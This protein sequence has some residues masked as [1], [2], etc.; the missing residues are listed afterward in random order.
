[1]LFFNTDLNIMDYSL[2]VGVHSGYVGPYDDEMRC[3]LVDRTWERRDDRDPDSIRGSFWSTGRL[4]VTFLAFLSPFE[5]C[6]CKR[7]LLLI[8][9]R[10]L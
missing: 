2:L 6:F 1:M 8:F 9:A 3:N 7:S 5:Y 4:Q 10:L